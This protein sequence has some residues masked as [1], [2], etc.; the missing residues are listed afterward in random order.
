[1]QRWVLALVAALLAGL[2]LLDVGGVLPGAGVAALPL[3]VLLGAGLVLWRGVWPGR[4]AR[5][6]SELEIPAEGAR[7]ARLEV[8]FGA[9]ELA[10]T[11]GAA[12]GPL[13]SGR[14]QGRAQRY[15]E[16][17]GE[18]VTMR[19]RQPFTL[20]GRRR[21]DWRLALAQGVKW[22]RVR[23][24]LGASTA[25]LDFSG[26]ALGRLELEV[27]GTALEVRL[28]RTGTVTLQMSGGRARLQAPAEAAVELVS[29]VKLGEVIVDEA[30]IRPLEVAGQWATPH[31]VDPT[32][33]LRIALKGGLGT[34]EVVQAGGG[35]GAA[36]APPPA[37]A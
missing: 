19:L 20:W 1:M 10:L 14:C 29:Q 11:A 12:G 6:S 23:L 2:V 30:H 21:A 17:K 32:E 24:A 37:T 31:V 28:P 9:G 27:G 8:I 16:R 13:V 34:I 33:T 4:A 26:L 7:T 35:P 25:A 3:L 36:A 15:V 22:E 18:T 5:A